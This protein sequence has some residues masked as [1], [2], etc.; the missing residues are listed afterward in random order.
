MARAA[1]LLA[2][3]GTCHTPDLLPPPLS[4]LDQRLFMLKVL[5]EAG[6]AEPFPDADR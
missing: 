1:T 2:V 6:R 3:G 5:R 4:I